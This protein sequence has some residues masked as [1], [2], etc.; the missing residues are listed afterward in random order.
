MGGSADKTRPTNASVVRL[1]P[2]DENRFAFAHAAAPLEKVGGGSSG[3]DAS[4]TK[5]SASDIRRS[6]K[7]MAGVVC[8]ERPRDA[9]RYGEIH[10][11]RDRHHLHRRLRLIEHGSGKDLDEIRIADEDG[12]RGVLDQVEVLRG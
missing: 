5:A 11:H 7:R 12:E 4:R 1:D 8:V 9:E 3:S 2:T 6:F 10:G